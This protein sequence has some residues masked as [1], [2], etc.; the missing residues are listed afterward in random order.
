MPLT[1]EAF[2]HHAKRAHL[3]SLVFNQEDN[4]V[5]EIKNPKHFGWKF[6][7]TRLYRCLQTIL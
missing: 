5:T 6:N 1:Y 4:V 3:Q 2:H 7:G